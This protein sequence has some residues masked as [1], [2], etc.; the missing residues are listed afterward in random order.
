MNVLTDQQRADLR[1]Q[2]WA[3]RVALKQRAEASVAEARPVSLDQPIGR[4]TRMDAMQQQQVALGQQQ[5]MGQELQLIEAALQR[6]DDNR[7]GSCLRCHND[8]PYDRLR[9]RPTTTL[10]LECQ[11]DLETNANKR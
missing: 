9:V 6:L 3:M 8:I 1:Q 7:F 11:G 5:R 4:L 10:C 2:L